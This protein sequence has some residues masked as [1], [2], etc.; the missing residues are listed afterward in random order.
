MRCDEEK[1]SCQRCLSTGR[2]CDGYS[3]PPSLETTLT[4][5]ERQPSCTADLK[6]VLP[7]QSTDELRSY[8][9]FLE[10]TAPSLAGVF[11][12]DFWLQ[13]MPRVC[14]ADPAI[15]HAVVSLGAVYEVYGAS[16]DKPAVGMAKAPRT[17]VFALQ[18]FNQSIRCLTESGSPRHADRWRALIVSTLFTCIC[19]LQGLYEQAKIHLQ[20]ACNLLRELQA[21]ET[22]QVGK[23]RR[24]FNDPM[25]P[26]LPDWWPLPTEDGGV[27]SSVPI[28]LAP[29]RSYLTNYEIQVY[30]MASGGFMGTEALV[31]HNDNYCAWSAYCAPKPSPR[32]EPGTERLMTP[33]N[34]VLANRAAE[35]LLNGI[36]YSAQSL[37]NVFLER[38]TGAGRTPNEVMEELTLNQR[39][40]WRCFN[41]LDKAVGVF[42][43]EMAAE[44][45]PGRVGTWDGND[46]KR[47]LLTL[48]LYQSANRFGLGAD[49]PKADVIKGFGRSPSLCD[50]VVDL[51]EELLQLEE[52]TN[53][54]KG[55]FLPIPYTTNPL[56]LMGHSGPDA[57]TRRRAL[58]LLRRRPRLEGMWDSVMT[59]T[60]VEV[61]RRR[62]RVVEREY[63]RID[64]LAE[65][66]QV[67]W[68]DDG[69]DDEEKPLPEISYRIARGMWKMKDGRRAVLE[70]S[71]WRECMDGMPWYS[72]EIIW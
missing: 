20:A 48:K 52:T 47:A 60:M 37:A 16:Y 57:K 45:K 50:S 49:V 46:L 44:E 43:A 36:M 9:Y 39:P 11:D 56:F 53:S 70:M 15:W 42:E 72:E 27:L 58:E 13:E 18:Q 26:A 38:F 71:T 40:H 3:P 63:Q 6:L 24:K 64:A 8:R 22:A 68:E 29:V 34:L 67:E 62:E 65:G 41:E 23:R 61:I 17:N 10:V 32:Y 35:S 21:Q 7:R 66:V 5:R 4:N 31:A 19:T 33:E 69:E 51:A 55:K 54:G 25:R 28:S 1:P 2:T 59:A 14:H 30:S 12:V